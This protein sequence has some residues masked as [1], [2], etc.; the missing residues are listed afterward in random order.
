MIRRTVHYSGH[1]QG[2]GFRATAEQLARRFSVAGYARNLDDGR[3]ELVVEGEPEEVKRYLSELEL[4]M[5]R[6]I[7]QALADD[8]PATGEFDRFRARL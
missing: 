7:R 6:H 3:V 5:A 4:T 8:S 1:V 2:V